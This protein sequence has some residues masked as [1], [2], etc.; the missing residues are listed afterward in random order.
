MNN[1]NKIKKSI[2]KSK[3]VS[4]SLSW[5]NFDKFFFDEETN[6]L[7]K[8]LREFL[9]KEIQ[10]LMVEYVEKASYP[11]KVVEKLK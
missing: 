7:R 6:Q 3:G 10:P 1:I 4:D 5:L 9:E 8:N 11:E 2:R